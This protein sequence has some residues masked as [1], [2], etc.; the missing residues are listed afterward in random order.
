[1]IPPWQGP[2]EPVHFVTAYVLTKPSTISETEVQRDVLRSMARYHWWDAF[3]TPTPDPLPQSFY[4]EPRRGFRDSDLSEPLYYSLGASVLRVTR[5]ASVESA[6]YQLRGLGVVLAVAALVMGW[7]GTRLLFGPAIATGALA[8]AA[9]N[10]QFLLSAITVNPDSLVIVCG[11]FAWW[12]AA[13]IV[14]GR[15]RALSLILLLI[16]AGAGILTQRL[17]VPLAGVALLIAGG[18]A[19]AGVST[20]HHWSSRDAG[21]AIAALGILAAVAAT[22]VLT[23]EEPFRIVSDSWQSAL[24]VTRP[25]EEITVSRLLQF[26]REAIDNTWLIAGWLRFRAPEPWYWIPRVLTLAGLF[27]AAVAVSQSRMLRLRL[28]LAWLFLVAQTIAIFFVVILVYGTGPQGRYFFPVIAPI[29]V[30]L[31]VG[32]TRCVPASLRQYVPV[33][34]VALLAVMDVTGLTMV[35]MP[36]YSSWSVEG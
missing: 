31:Y 14:M 4:N 2:D 24:T 25:V 5:A 33:A 27:G 29:T 23:Y 1:L 12:Q 16:A 18:V 34:L 21:R 28:S 22:A 32:L 8:L 7:A 15:R 17:A 9:L 26:F 30:L 20:L 11:G 35:L 10:P 3:G 13:R 36:V 6:Y 19:L